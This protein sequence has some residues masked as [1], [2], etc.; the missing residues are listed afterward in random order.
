MQLELS[1]EETRAVIN[2]LESYLGNL[3]AEIAGT[4]K[5]EWRVAL[6]A[7]EEALKRVMARLS[8]DG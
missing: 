2:A 6:H 7:E 1:E 4:E 3:R 8:P 5:H